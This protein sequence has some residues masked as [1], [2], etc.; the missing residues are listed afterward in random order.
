[1]TRHRSADVGTQQ[2]DAIVDQV[3]SELRQGE[4]VRHGPNPEPVTTH[5]PPEPARAWSMGTIS[6][7]MS[8]AR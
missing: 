5:G 2:I 1:M 6:S 8:T 7:P 4:R 3:M